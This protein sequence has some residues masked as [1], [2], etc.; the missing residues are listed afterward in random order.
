MKMPKAIKVDDIVYAKWPGSTKY[1]KA[2]VTAIE[3]DGQ[4]DVKFESDD[5]NETVSRKQLM[6]QDEVVKSKSPSRRRS[7]SRSASPGRRRSRSRSPSRIKTSS[8][9][10]P[11]RSPVARQPRSPARSRRTIKSSKSPEK[12]PPKKVESPKLQRVRSEKSVISNDEIK[13]KVEEINSQE[14]TTSTVRT[15]TTLNNKQDEPVFSQTTLARRTTRSVTRALEQESV[16]PEKVAA[17]CSSTSTCNVVCFLKSIP[18]LVFTL[19]ALVLP[20]FFLYG[21][22]LSCKSKKT[23]T[24]IAMPVIPDCSKFF[25]WK[26]TSIVFG[27]YIFQMVLSALPLGRVVTG[28]VLI[29]GKARNYCLN[30]FSQLT[31]SMATLAGLIYYGKLPAKYLTVNYLSLITAASLFAFLMSFVVY[32]AS[33]NA[34]SKEP[35]GGVIND[36]MKGRVVDARIGNFDLKMFAFK[37]GFVSWIALSLVFAVKSLQ[38]DWKKN[39]SLV[40][41]LCAQ[42]MYVMDKLCSEEQQ[43]H[44]SSLKSAKVGFFWLV[45]SLATIP[46]FCSLQA[47]YLSIHPTTLPNMH[48]IVPFL[49]IVSGFFIL[50]Q[51]RQQKFFFRK[52]KYD[53]VAKGWKYIVTRNGKG[54]LCDGLWA[55]LTHPNYFGDILQAVGW[56]LLCG[57]RHFLP[58]TNLCM[59]LPMILCQAN[60]DD[61]ACQ[62][63][64]GAAWSE[65]REKVK[66]RVIRY[67]Y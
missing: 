55:Q 21:L 1:F 49:I 60:E 2:I 37:A 35:S 20:P 51:S 40:G 22:F 38:I 41:M 56:A 54:I 50:T 28:P 6:T 29:D 31:I 57:T 18:A 7:R 42:G 13:T 62:K 39:I 63:K 64:Y 46:F 3:E 12:S 36:F 59:R 24:L 58:W 48:Y 17:V 27:W 5:S 32:L 47:R 4:Y 10:K 8:P 53:A 44:T 67:V 23:C 30:G 33:R 34:S 65:Y 11:S 26:A 16:K 66:Y 19:I 25:S 45:T 15:A 43:L 9:A 52:N 61:K 14:I